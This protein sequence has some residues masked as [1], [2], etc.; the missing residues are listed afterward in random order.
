MP[1]RR[2]VKPDLVNKAYIAVGQDLQLGLR[3]ERAS[4]APPFGGFRCGEGGCRSPKSGQ[5]E[6]RVTG[7]LTD[8]QSVGQ[9]GPCPG[10][11]SPDRTCGHRKERSIPS[12]KQ[13]SLSGSRRL[14]ERRARSP[15]KSGCPGILRERPGAAR[16]L[17]TKPKTTTTG[18]KA[19][20]CPRCDHTDC[21]HWMWGEKWLYFAPTL[22][23]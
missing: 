4:S 19:G 14:V 20:L 5:V 17:S 1:I 13:V 2:S 8:R 23:A 3:R 9:N 15:E 12:G 7:V 16:P 21:G 11:R 10:T 22:H 18:R 6:A